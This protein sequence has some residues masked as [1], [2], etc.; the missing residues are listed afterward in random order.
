MQLLQLSQQWDERA[1]LR[2]DDF[3]AMVETRAVAD[4]AASAVQVM[5]I[6]QAK[7][8]EFDV[9][10]LPELEAE[11]ASTR[12]SRSSTSATATPARSLA[13]PDMSRRTCGRC[14]RTCARCSSSTSA[15]S[16]TRPC[17]CSTSPS[18]AR[19]RACSCSSTPRA[20]GSR[21][22]PARMSSLV[23]HALH[24]DGPVVEPD[25]VVFEWGDPAWMAPH[26]PVAPPSGRPVRAAPRD[27]AG[28]PDLRADRG[29]AA[30]LV[31]L[32]GH[33]PDRPHR[34]RPARAQRRP[35][36]RLERGHPRPVRRDRV[37]RRLDPQ[38]RP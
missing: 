19:A 37:A 36:Q 32:A 6:H 2:I 17:A 4:P 30:A 27:P 23:L 22:P 20:E 9:V 31:G 7:G 5:T 29:P 14:S 8:L 18:P 38:P 26:D 24:P 11:L 3:V 25:Q 16:P 28:R 13:S 12:T 1:S 21:T 10:I 15:G 35:C 34:R 33:R